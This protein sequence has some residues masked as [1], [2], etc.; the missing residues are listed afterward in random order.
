MTPLRA[1]TI[2]DI[3][4]GKKVTRDKAKYKNFIT[5]LNIGCSSKILT[6]RLISKRKKIKYDVTQQKIQLGNLTTNHKVKVNLCLTESRATKIVMW[7][8]HMDD[9]TESGYYM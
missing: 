2:C 1:G 6:I 9:S 5:L 4:N 3:Y 8:C 7:D